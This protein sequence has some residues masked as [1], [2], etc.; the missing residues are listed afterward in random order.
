MLFDRHVTAPFH[1]KD[2]KIEVT[3]PDYCLYPIDQEEPQ[4]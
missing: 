4:L 2:R 1:P 3:A